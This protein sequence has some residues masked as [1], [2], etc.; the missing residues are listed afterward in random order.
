MT[1][2][3]ALTKVVL[4]ARAQGVAAVGS[5][6]NCV[7]WDVKG[8]RCFMGCL[9]TE[10]KARTATALGADVGDVAEGLGLDDLFASDLVQIH[11]NK[12]PELWE[13]ELGGV[14][15]KWGLSM[16]GQAPTSAPNAG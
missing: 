9:L 15:E 4:H 7:Y 10:E 13:S 12:L 16:P 3:E 14:A 11:D 5:N 2:Q 6:G 8:R 1:K